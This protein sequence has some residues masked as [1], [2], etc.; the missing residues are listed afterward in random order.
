MPASGRAQ[1]AARL[2][3][4]HRGHQTGGDYQRRGEENLINVAYSA[5]SEPRMNE[6]PAPHSFEHSNTYLPALRRHKRH[7]RHAFAALG[8][9]DVDIGADDAEAVIGVVAA[10]ANFNGS[11]GLHAK[12]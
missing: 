7:R 9:R 2:R 4:Q 12:L 6:W 3:R 8:Y 10:Q 1:R 11:A 5:I